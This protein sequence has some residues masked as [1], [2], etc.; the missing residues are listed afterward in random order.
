MRTQSE[1]NLK[2]LVTAAK[3]SA[4]IGITVPGFSNPSGRSCIIPTNSHLM[5]VIVSS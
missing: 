1:G 3:T 2:A 5:P 4:I